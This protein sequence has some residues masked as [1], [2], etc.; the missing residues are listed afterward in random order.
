MKYRDDTVVLLYQFISLLS[1]VYVIEFVYLIYG[2][3]V[4]CLIRSVVKH[5]IDLNHNM[6]NE[7]SQHVYI[8]S[9][10]TDKLS[11]IAAV[12]SCIKNHSQTAVHN[13]KPS[14]TVFKRTINPTD[15]HS[16]ILSLFYYGV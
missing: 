16:E 13:N 10:A 7:A 14:N 11:C 9:K 4:N 1:T 15:I 3:N 5:A 6:L 2:K 12:S 8:L